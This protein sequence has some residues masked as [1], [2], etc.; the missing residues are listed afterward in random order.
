[1]LKHNAL[2]SPANPS[3]FQEAGGSKPHTGLIVAETM[4]TI[5]GLYGQLIGD[6]DWPIRDVHPAEM[7]LTW[8]FGEE[9]A[10]ATAAEPVSSRR[11][12][13][14]SSAAAAADTGP[15]DA[16]LMDL[17]ARSPTEAGKAFD[18]RRTAG[19]HHSLGQ[20]QSNDDKGGEEGERGQL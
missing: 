15:S 10:D 4:N 7:A 14:S 2:G 16:V 13:A 17:V 9:E 19:P 12:A 1:M 3:Y 11:R 6:P 20:D 5:R 18:E 8:K